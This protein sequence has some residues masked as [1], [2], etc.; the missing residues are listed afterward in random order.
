LWGILER[1]CVETKNRIVFGVS[2][3]VMGV[4][5]CVGNGNNGGKNYT[6]E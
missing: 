6:Y 2:C 3:D 5:G 4:Y 1:K